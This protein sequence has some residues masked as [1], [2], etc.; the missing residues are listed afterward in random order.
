MDEPVS[1]SIYRDK[2]L[3]EQEANILLHVVAFGEAQLY[4][5]AR[6]IFEE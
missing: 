3:A 6:R 5:I 4:S 2:S 1:Y